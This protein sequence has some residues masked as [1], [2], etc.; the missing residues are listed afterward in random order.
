[1]AIR[2]TTLSENTAGLPDVLAEWGLSILIEIDGQDILLDTG[3][4]LSISQNADYLGI[5]LQRID[6]IVLSHGHFDHTGGLHQLLSKMKKEVEIIA[7][8]DVWAPKY[9]R[10]EDKPDRY[11]GIPY[12]LRVLESLGA[13][14]NLSTQPVRVT[15][16][17]MTTGEVPMITDFE[18]IESSLFVR[19]E[20][21]WEPDPLRDDMALVLQTRL[22]LVVILGCAH[23]GM[24]NT[25]HQAIKIS[26][27]S[28]IHM[29]LGGCHL[30]DASDEIIWQSISSL[31]EL[32]VKKLGVSHCTG[33][34]ATLLLA[35]TYGDDF[36]F[37][38][39]G[40]VIE[41][42]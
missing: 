22:G 42:Q 30:K 9:N 7:H 32:G 27:S 13:K 2:I 38:N 3:K 25:L 35:Q 39:T 16:N 37:N 40:N 24:I 5:D 36:I 34:R 10:H 17:L 11:I 31:N 8:P 18:K 19:T 29:V 33:M 23:R 26:D 20:N 12:Q 1:M 15:E 4:S 14:F 6:K 21:G 28:Q 41:I